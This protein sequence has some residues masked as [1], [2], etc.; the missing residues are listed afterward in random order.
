MNTC[1]VTEKSIPAIFGRWEDRMLLIVRHVLDD[2]LAGVEFL[3][4]P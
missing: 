2:G 3:G 1:L 4:S